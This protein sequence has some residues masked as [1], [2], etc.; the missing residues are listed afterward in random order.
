MGV[1]VAGE[2]LRGVGKGGV[3]IHAADLRLRNAGIISDR[4]ALSGGPNKRLNSGSADAASGEP[5]DPNQC[6]GGR[7]DKGGTPDKNLVSL[8]I[9]SHDGISQQ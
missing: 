8:V 6:I 2:L 7:A 5:N 1:S 9:A 3:F 4:F